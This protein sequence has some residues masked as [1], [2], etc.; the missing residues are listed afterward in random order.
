MAVA[1]EIKD[2]SVRYR[3]G[4]HSVMT[5]TRSELAP[6]WW[7]EEAVSRRPAESKRGEATQASF[8]EP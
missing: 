1:S 3:H 4:P 8:V 5:R 2:V 6:T 7:E